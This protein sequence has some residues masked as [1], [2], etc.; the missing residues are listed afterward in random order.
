MKRAIIK[1]TGDTIT[2]IELVTGEG[3]DPRSAA[4]PDGSVQMNTSFREYLSTITRHA[5]ESY[6]LQMLR[7]YKGNVNQIAKLMDIDRKTVYRKMGEY[8]IDPDSFR[9]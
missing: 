7:L 4:P 9:D 8:Q 2:S 5:E 6:L 3:P 1:S